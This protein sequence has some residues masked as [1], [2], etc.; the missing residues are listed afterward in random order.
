MQRAR[1]DLIGKSLWVEYPQLVNSITE[2]ECRKAARTGRAVEFEY[3]DTPSNTWAM[4]RVTPSPEGVTVYFEDI[5]ERRRLR[6][7]KDEQTGLLESIAANA[8]LEQVL[9]AAAR[10][11]PVSHPHAVCT[12]MLL[13]DDGRYLERAAA[14][15]SCV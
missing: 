5:T 14:S 9:A 7:F 4:V 3:F 1:Q 15:S 10:I 2:H 8:P 12:I 13:S 6:L 11:T